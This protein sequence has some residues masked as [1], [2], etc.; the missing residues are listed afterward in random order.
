MN[1]LWVRYTIVTLAVGLAIA[2]FV[3]ASRLKTHPGSFLLFSL[4][5]EAFFLYA[6]FKPRVKR[7]RAE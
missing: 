4:L 5:G 6:L 7:S 2:I 1:R 3:V